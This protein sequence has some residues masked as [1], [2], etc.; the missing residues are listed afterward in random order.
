MFQVRATRN[1]LMHST[2]LKLTGSK[3]SDYLKTT[4]DLLTDIHQ[5]HCDPAIPGVIDDIVKV[6]II[7][8]TIVLIFLAST[9]NLLINYTN[10]H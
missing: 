4:T 1:A 3:L 9:I 10:I 5:Q 8:S 7:T 2:D 6:V